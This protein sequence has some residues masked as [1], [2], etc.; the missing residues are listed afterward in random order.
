MGRV[1]RLAMNTRPPTL[2]KATEAFLDHA[3]LARRVLGV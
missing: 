3:D 1:T 2:G